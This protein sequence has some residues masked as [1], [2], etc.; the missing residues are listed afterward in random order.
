MSVYR[1]IYEAL[2]AHQD[3]VNPYRKLGPEVRLMK[4][5]EEVGEVMEAYIGVVGANKR[6]G[7]AGGPDTVA[8]ELCD[9]VITAMVALHDWTD[10]PERFL[11]EHLQGLMRRISEEG[12]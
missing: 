10:S 3:G 6:K 11:K 12:S 5:S 2:A 8:K 4:L 7:R 1:D 9:V